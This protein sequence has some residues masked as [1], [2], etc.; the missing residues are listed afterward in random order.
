[1]SLASQKLVYEGTLEAMR[2]EVSQKS[3]ELKELQNKRDHYMHLAAYNQAVFE[4]LAANLH[5]NEL[6]EKAGHLRNEI[7]MKDKQLL[8]YQNLV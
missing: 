7:A 6:Q 5:L 2:K 3:D 4:K 8:E 1:M